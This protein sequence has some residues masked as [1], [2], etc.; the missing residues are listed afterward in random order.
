MP[1]PPSRRGPASTP[2]PAEGRRA[3]ILLADDNADMRA[4]VGRL[5]RQRWD[6]EAVADGSA[7]LAAIRARRPDLVL[8][9][10]MMPN[11]DGFGLLRRCAPTRETRGTPVIMLSARAGEEAKV[12]GLHAGADDYLV[13]PFSARELVARV[14]THLLLNRLRAAAETE[15]MRLHALFMSAPAIVAILKGPDHVFE[16]ANP[17]ALQMIGHRQVVGR[18][19]REAVAELVPQG[20]IDIM[21]TVYRTGTPYAAQ[22]APLKLDR[23]N[24]GQLSDVFVNFVFQPSFGADGAVDGILV[25]GFEVTDQV[26]ARRKI[27]DEHRLAEVAQHQAEAAVHARDEFLS[28]ASHELRTPL[29]S[30]CLQAD[31]ALLALAR[32]AAQPAG[33]FLGRVQKIRRQAGRLEVLVQD[34][35]D[36]T[37]LNAG[38]LELRPE[39]VELTEIARD[40][41]DRLREQ[42]E[43]AGSVIVLDAVRPVHGHWD[44]VRLDQ[45]ITNLLINAIKYGQGKAVEVSVAVPSGASPAILR[46]RDHGMGIAPENHARI[47]DRFERA[48]SDRNEGDWVWDSGSPASSS[49]SWAGRSPS[50]AR[51]ARGRRSSSSCRPLPD[52]RRMRR[53]P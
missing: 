37:R 52:A 34:L 26:L 48:V 11:L 5:L 10:V 13:K 43:R 36:V 41:C 51:R 16:L 3:R 23:T 31:G 6:V 22:E 18:P 12:D 29:T 4:Y 49:S 33:N 42:A 44:P 7:A 2:A 25:Y 46:V 47:F 32:D 19:V 39:N 17:P 28:I 53:F 35:L 30:L 14:E 38:R 50:T 1:C 24:D 21:D 45:V 20:M 15:R 8:T 27:E 40:V 9:D